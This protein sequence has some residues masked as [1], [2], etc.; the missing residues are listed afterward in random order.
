M[1]AG[2][3][4]GIMAGIT[5]GTV[6]GITPGIVLGMVDGVGMEVG[7]MDITGTIT[8]IIIPADTTAAVITD[9]EILLMDD[10][11][12]RWLPATEL[13]PAGEMLLP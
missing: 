3:T 8:I 10:A 9:M 2:T 7:I 12:L 4:L 1:T 13:R 6:P 11:P 5:L